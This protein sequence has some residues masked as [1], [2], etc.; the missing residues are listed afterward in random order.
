MLIRFSDG[1]ILMGSIQMYGGLWCFREGEFENEY[2]YNALI[3]P[4]PLSIEFN[5]TYFEKLISTPEFQR[6]SLKALRIY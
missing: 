2:R 1:T 4:S 5:N 3:K 6:L